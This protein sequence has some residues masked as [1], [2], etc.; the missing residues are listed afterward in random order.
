L[1]SG[2]DPLTLPTVANAQEVDVSQVV[3]ADGWGGGGSC[4]KDKTIN[5]LGHSIVLP[6]S[7]ICEY[8]IY[9]RYA[10]M[11]MASLVSFRMLSGSILRS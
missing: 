5:L 1:L 2:A 4:F 3:R 8:L 7:R 6:I 9:L 11:L 10:I